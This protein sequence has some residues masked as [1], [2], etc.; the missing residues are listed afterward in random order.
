MILETI[1]F[2][3]GSMVEAEYRSR[4]KIREIVA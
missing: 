1:Y 4:C 3:D 2:N